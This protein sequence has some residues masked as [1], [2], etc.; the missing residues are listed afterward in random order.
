M[1]TNPLR[2][3]L[4]REPAALLAALTLS[5][6][7]CSASGVAGTVS[8]PQSQLQNQAAGAAFPVEGESNLYVRLAKQVVPSVVNISTVTLPKAQGPRGVVP[9]GPEDMFRHFFGDSFGPY[10]G[11]QTR[12]P[13]RGERPV[14]QAVPR[15]ASLGTGFVVDA[16]GLILT[17]N[18]VVAGAD[19]IRIT[20]TEDKDEKPTDAKVVGRDPDLDVAIIRVKTDRKLTP[21][22]LGDS[23]ALEVGEWVAA[24]G[25]PFGQGHSLTHGIISAKGRLAPDFPLASYIQT[26]API[27]PGNSG[28]PLV[29]TR[30][31][32]I[33]INTAIDARAQG[34]GFAIPVNLVK[35][36]LPQLESKGLVARGYLGVLIGALTPEL[37]EQVKMKKDAV[38]ALVTHV[39]PDSPAARAGI[40]PYDVILEADGKPVTSPGDLTSRVAGLEAGKEIPLKISRDGFV[41]NVRIKL[42]QR[43]M[44][45]EMG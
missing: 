45:E 44:P 14:P 11:P 20:F 26:D 27:N 39:V 37:A 30:G 12:R 2:R 41:K 25:N 5:I 31:E 22:R 15:A 21:L 1:N 16:S 4:H 13:F 24:V 17:N 3:K 43:P 36:V 9:G 42:G 18:H 23:D 7:G 28:G 19:E 40:E 10:Y 34:I 8:P 6:A 32:V 33:G 29:N 35:A 38:A